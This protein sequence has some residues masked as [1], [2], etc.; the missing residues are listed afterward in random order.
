MRRLTRAR[1]GL[2]VDRISGPAD[3][4][5]KFAAIVVGV[6][7]VAVVFFGPKIEIETSR[8]TF[9]DRGVLRE[10][11]RAADERVPRVVS[12]VVKEYNDANTLDLVLQQNETGDKLSSR[13]I[14]REN[15][16][17][18]QA[19]FPATNC[20]SDDPVIGRNHFWERLIIRRVAEQP[21]LTPEAAATLARAAVTRLQDAQFVK[22]RTLVHNSGH[23]RAINVNVRVPVGFSP[24]TS[25]QSVSPFTLG[26]DDPGVERF[27][28]TE[29]GVRE[30]RFSRTIEGNIEGAPVTRFAVDWERDQNSQASVI[31]WVGA[32]F[33][34]LWVAIVFN[35]SRL[36][37]RDENTATD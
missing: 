35:D 17:L 28:R 13:K 7:A 37:R 4:G 23:G 3:L 30:S 20:D 36:R 14:C 32:G 6:G 18:L 11:Y 19:V 15:A 12:Q 9:L 10:A 21:D 31:V 22:V 2:T 25:D 1:H 8:Q 33:F 34:V 24:D 26:S 29:A 27:Y 5:V 16:E